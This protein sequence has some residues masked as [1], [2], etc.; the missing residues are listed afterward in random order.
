MPLMRCRKN[1]VLGWKFGR[2]GTCYTGPGAEEAAKRQGRAIKVNQMKGKIAA[3]LDMLGQKEPTKVQTLIFSKDKFTKQQ[4]TK[5]ATDH[6]FH[7]GKVDETENS[8]RLRQMDPGK[9]KEDF[10]TIELTDGVKAELV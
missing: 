9:F 6:D 2:S 1:G 10:S 8:Y 4:A 7:S 5:W 3:I